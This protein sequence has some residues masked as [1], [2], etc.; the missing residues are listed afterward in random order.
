MSNQSYTDS[1][2][3]EYNEDGSQTITTVERYY[4]PTTQQKIAAWATLGGL[5]LVA[6]APAVIPAAIDSWQERKA[7]KAREKSNSENTEK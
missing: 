1:T 3:V 2:I 4:P 5:A 7:R 6:V